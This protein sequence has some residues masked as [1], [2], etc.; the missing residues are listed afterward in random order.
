MPLFTK[1]NQ[2]THYLVRGHGEPLLMIHGLGSSGADWAMQV[3]ALHAELV[4]IR[5]S[6]HGTPFDSIAATNA[7]LLALLT[8]TALPSDSQN[9]CDEQELSY[10]LSFV[11]SLAEQHALGPQS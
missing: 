1:S 5:G 3:P 7:I 11:G 10:P 2:S 8:D 6:R 4:V 9:E